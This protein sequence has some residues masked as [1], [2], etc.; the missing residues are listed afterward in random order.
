[1]SHRDV[2]GMNNLKNTDINQRHIY[3]NTDGIP[4]VI[5]EY[6]NNFGKPY[7][8]GEFGFEWDWS[9]NFNDFADGMDND[10]RRGLWY[11]LFSP[12]PVLPM[13]WWWEFFEN[14]DMMEYFK[15]VRTFSDTMLQ[16]CTDGFESFEVSTGNGKFHTF[17]VHCTAGYYVYVYNNS[18][19]A[20]DITITTRYLPVTNRDL[21][22]YNCETGIFK[23]ERISVT[24]GNTIRVENLH[25]QGKS[26]LILFW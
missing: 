20:G 1:V 25:L 14:R 15:N 6:T 13:S 2:G 12:T 17:G 11:G 23:S 7:V 21:K 8:I 3:K 9:K 16:S 24:G 18:A 19:D 4:S 22:T 10:F 26:G 5:N